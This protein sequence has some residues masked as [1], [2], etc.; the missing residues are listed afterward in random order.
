M[1]L[2]VARMLC[3]LNIQYDYPVDKISQLID[4]IE[5]DFSINLDDQQRKL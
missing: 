5:D 1:E 3:D 4:D 2:N